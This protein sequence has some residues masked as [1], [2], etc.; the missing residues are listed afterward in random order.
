MQMFGRCVFYKQ[1]TLN[2]V[3]YVYTSTLLHLSRSNIVNVFV[4]IVSQVKR[5]RLK[6][7][8]QNH[9]RGGQ[10]YVHNRGLRS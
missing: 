7:T 2:F 8:R 1:N 3:E 4:Q 9:G 10:F 5:M 6:W